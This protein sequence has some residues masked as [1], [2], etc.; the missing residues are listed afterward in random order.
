MYLYGGISNTIHPLFHRKLCSEPPLTC[1]WCYF[2]LEENW[3]DWFCLTRRPTFSQQPVRKTW[4]LRYRWCAVLL[5]GTWG[6]W[7]MKSRLQIS[8]QKASLCCFYCRYWANVFHRGPWHLSYCT[9]KYFIMFWSICDKFT[10]DDMCLRKYLTKHLVLN[11]STIGKIQTSMNSKTCKASMWNCFVR[12][13]EFLALWRNSLHIC[14]HAFVH[15]SR[16]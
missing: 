10:V 8:Q 4:K 9:L 2:A 12:W 13:F 14:V 1:L 3:K 16:G 5:F 15:M 6:L 7:C 11:I